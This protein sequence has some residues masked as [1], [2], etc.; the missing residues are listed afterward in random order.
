MTQSEKCNI[1]YAVHNWT[2]R[3]TAKSRM[4]QG[5]RGRPSYSLTAHNYY[6]LEMISLIEMRRIKTM[7]QKCTQ[8]VIRNSCTNPKGKFVKSENIIVI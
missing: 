2:K 3:D 5:R 8:E 1:Y 6:A 7:Q 4:H